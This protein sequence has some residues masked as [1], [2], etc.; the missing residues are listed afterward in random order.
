MR[1]QTVALLQ[2]ARG[3]NL[4]W[5]DLRDGQEAVLA[6]VRE[7]ESLAGVLRGLNAAVVAVD[8][9]GVWNYLSNN[10]YLAALRAWLGR[11]LHSW[12]LGNERGCEAGRDPTTS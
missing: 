1:L 8:R 10:W 2:R 4:W 9:L 7:V 3:G 5:E 11:G 12:V 6:A